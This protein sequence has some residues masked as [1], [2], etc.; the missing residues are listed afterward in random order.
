MVNHIVYDSF[1]NVVSETNATVDSRYL[2]TGRNYDSETGLYFYRARYYDAAIGKFLGEDIFIVQPTNANQ[3]AYVGNSPAQ[4]VDPTGFEYYRPNDYFPG[5][6]PA[7]PYDPKNP[8]LNG[9]TDSRAKELLKQGRYNEAWRAEQRAVQ[10]ARK[11]SERATRVAARKAAQKTI[12]RRLGVLG[13][14]YTAFEV[15]YF[16]GEK[17]DCYAGHEVDAVFD[18][19]GINSILKNIA[20]FVEGRDIFEEN[21]PP[22]QTG[23]PFQGHPNFG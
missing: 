4:F 1:G 23:Y 6:D 11:A 8:N 3:Y 2:F 5:L 13:A 16:I 9:V 19:T 10:A 14:A 21:E 18:A 15:G 20:E 22:P 17:I 7:N 12:L